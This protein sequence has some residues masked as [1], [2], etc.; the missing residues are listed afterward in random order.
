MKGGRPL[1]RLHHFARRHR[2]LLAC[3]AAYAA[4][5]QYSIFLQAMLAWPFIAE[6][7]GIPATC[8]MNARAT[9][10]WMNPADFNASRLARGGGG[11]GRAAASGGG[12][13][14]DLAQALTARV[15]GSV[16]SSAGDARG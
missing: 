16:A 8:G 14:G 1:G 15:F 12:E 13:S 4:A 9:D 2:V 5:S 7:D 11:G 10:A 6:L 3:A